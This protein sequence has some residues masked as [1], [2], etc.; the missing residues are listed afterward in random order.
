MKKQFILALIS[1]TSLVGCGQNDKPS[2]SESLSE[3]TSQTT[4]YVT[5]ETTSQ[6]ESTSSSMSTSQNQED[7]K[8]YMTESWDDQIKY[9][10]DKV[11]GSGS[12][13]VPIPFG[14]HYFAFYET[15]DNISC[16]VI[17]TYG[18]DENNIEKDYSKQLV[19][20]KFML[21][22]NPYGYYMISKT[23]DLC[24]QYSIVDAQ[25]AGKIFQL[26]IYRITTRQLEFPEQ[27]VNQVIGQ[28]IPTPDC[29]SYSAY[30]DQYNLK[31]S[32]Y[33]NSIGLNG[34]VDYHNKVLATNN[35][36]LKSNTADGYIYSS[37]DG[38]INLE[39][40]PAYDEYNRESLLIRVSSYWPSL[41][42]LLCVGE[43]LPK[44]FD[45]Y[46]SNNVSF[47]ITEDN[48]YFLIYNDYAEEELYAS[49]CQTLVSL[50]WTIVDETS[51][52][53]SVSKYFSK[54][55]N[56][57]TVEFSV[58]YGTSTINGESIQTILLIFSFPQEA[59]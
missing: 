54:N 57:K 10:I 49:Y 53:V 1:L 50:G 33:A 38:Y 25:E 31:V 40:Y 8:E 27:L 51:G 37:K 45:E 29:E 18:A 13:Y 15:I 19:D 48:N 55:V 39:V 7:I 22:S 20:A 26:I 34:L 42:I 21:G 16:T 2:S 43:P 30:F 11:S 6:N 4:S 28:S 36:V 9:M 41:Y 44:V 35:F 32:I 59:K 52:S 24:V 5:S 47:A 58:S 56:G 17:G 46:V 12:N 3:P 23:D 14:T